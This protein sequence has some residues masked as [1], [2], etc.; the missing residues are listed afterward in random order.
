MANVETL[1]IVAEFDTVDK[2]SEA[3]DGLGVSAD[4]AENKTDKFRKTNEKLAGGMTSLAKKAGAL[5]LAY[6][7]VASLKIAGSAALDLGTAL[8]EVST[9]IEGT[10]EQLAGLSGS[11]A[12][13]SKQFGT[14]Q[15]QQANAYYQAISAGAKVGKEATELL[16]QANKFAIGGV[17]NVTTGIDALTTATNAY[18]ASGLTAAEAS[19]AL[20]VGIKAG[21]TT[22]AELSSALGKIVPIAS[23]VGVSFDETVAGIAALTTTG[24]STAESVTS[25]NQVM[26]SVLKPTKEAREE[27]KRL[28]VEF[29]ATALSSKG[30]AGFMKSLKDAGGLTTSSIVKL[31]GSVDALKAAMALAGV[32][33]EKYVEILGDMEVKAGATDVAFDKMSD[34]LQKRL[35]KVMSEVGA[36][37]LKV[38]QGLV[39]VL[40]PALEA[41]VKAVKFLGDNSETLG[42]IMLALA[43]TQ[44][45]AAIGAL[46]TYTAG[47]SAA[48]V[49]TGVLTGLVGTLR[50]AMALAGGPI[51]LAVGAVTLLVGAIAL[52]K[53][54]TGEMKSAI[55]LAE[56]AQ[57]DLNAQMAHF[58]NNVSAAN[59]TAL[60]ESARANEELART[61]LLAAKAELLKV[62]ALE[63]GFIENP[64]RA[65]S[66]MTLEGE[67]TDDINLDA[68]TQRKLESLELIA[69]AE[70]KLGKAV[71]DRITSEIE[72]KILLAD[73]TRPKKEDDPET[74]PETDIEGGESLREKMQGRLD[75]LL[76]GLMTERE[77]L[78]EWKAESLELLRIAEE[79]ELI[80]ADVHKEAKLRV[81][82][83]YQDRLR[84]IRGKGLAGALGDASDFFGKMISLSG[85]RSKKL[86]AIQNALAKAEILV[87]TWR[88]AAQTLADPEVPYFAKFVAVASVVAAGM[89]MLSSIGGAGSGAGVDA[90]AG[91][92]SGPSAAPNQTNVNDSPEAQRLILD[93]GGVPLIPTAMLKELVENLQEENRNGHIIG[94]SL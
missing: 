77:A 27:A 69:A 1:G 14:T 36:A 26:V 8:A 66:L 89:G 13:L 12:N 47:V 38:G 78:D 9:L 15:T 65:R 2:S 23:Q 92:T 34:T 67:G 85:S 30:L 6:A 80:D 44:I 17:T 42:V 41:G 50:V 43:A 21:K 71:H 16:T 7:S 63:K 76:G 83:E 11:V 58:V 39:S 45:P 61:A 81:E 19:D 33:G 51:G 25:L 59:F 57:A 24:L 55:E 82:E 32:T 70:E 72:G 94:V 4:N 3:L 20:F 75:A 29:N 40:I 28:K 10:P 68:F 79:Q 74:I 22:A 53:K 88:A 62:E 46:V 49:A 52:M 60:S 31:F 5:A 87:N 93:F 37:V 48:G 90:A 18:K 35:D 73:L 56:D 54:P 86:L 91:S 84:G 64:N